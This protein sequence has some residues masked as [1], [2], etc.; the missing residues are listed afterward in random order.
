MPL[1]SV[2]I[3]TRNRSVLLREAIESVLAVHRGVFELE[4]IVVD[5]GSTDSAREVASAYP[6]V[7][8]RTEGLGASAAR[9]AGMDAA[10]GEFLAF[11]DDDDV[12]LPNNVAPQ[13]SM[14]DGHPEYGAA[15]AQVQLTDAN[16][17]PYGDPIP[18]GPLQSG[19]IFDDL[20]TYWPQL[21]SIVVRTAVAREIGGFDLTLRSEEEWDWILRIARR[22]PI[23]RIEEPVLLFRQR[24]YGDE[25]LAWRR[26]PDTIKVFQRHTSDA[27]FSRW[28]HLQRLLW[29]HRGWYASGFVHSA[30]HH[31]RQ[32]DRTRALRCLHYALRTSPLHAIA[33]LATSWHAESEVTP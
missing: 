28:L 20:L 18:A 19:W 7:Y 21:G 24:G 27:A 16:R 25:A 23:G 22:Y 32:G 12:W 11:L 14:L 8:L 9:N 29:S 30:R 13:L 15:Y 33:M 2:I 17:V 3:P 26:L 31:A 1:V 4:V 10:R 5:D 6:V